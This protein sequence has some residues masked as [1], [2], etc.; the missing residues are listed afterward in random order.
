MQVFRLRL[1]SFGVW[2]FESRPNSELSSSFRSWMRFF[3]EIRSVGLLDT[4]S[5]AMSD[6]SCY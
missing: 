4:N 2:V 3:T 6:D 1:I 5:V